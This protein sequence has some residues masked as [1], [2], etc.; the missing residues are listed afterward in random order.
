ML[1]RVLDRKH[2]GGKEYLIVDAGM[3][4]LLRPSHYNAFHRIEAVVPRGGREI[5]DVVGPVCESGDFLALDREVDAALPGDLMAVRS[6]GAYGYSM[7]SNYNSRPRAAEVLVDGDRFAVI[8]ARESYED[9]I[10]QERLLPE[11]R[12][13]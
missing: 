2:S 10:R 6:A 4:D 13:R 8:S 7:A 11:W 12:H 9:L 1:T 5:V 3:N